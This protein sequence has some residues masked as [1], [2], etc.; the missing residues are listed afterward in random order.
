MR[1]KQCEAM[2]KFGH[3]TPRYIVNRVRWALYEKRNPDKPWLTPDAI[4][5]LDRLLVPSD[6]GL[7]WGSGRS[8]RWF[9]KR[10]KHLTSVEDH[11][12][13]HARV[14]NQLRDA[15]ITNVTYERYDTPEPGRESESQYVRVAERFEPRS[16][17]F[18]LVDGQARD[19]CAEAVLD[20]IVVGGVLVI[21]NA[22]WYLDRQSHAPG[23]RGGQGPAN[24][25]WAGIHERL[26]QWRHVWT[27][28][29][30][31]DTAIWIR[32]HSA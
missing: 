4:R 8:T 14:S 6:L 24:P 10:V 16:L 30:V 5:I 1:A 3:L 27:T 32:P 9:A 23:S 2:R 21:D 19:F 18:V 15:G 7:E 29:G 25:R 20:K 13:W 12:E 31:T 26:N 17:G 28:Q 11:P 22:N